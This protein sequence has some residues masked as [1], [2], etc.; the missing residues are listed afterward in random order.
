LID[1]TGDLA[2]AL[3]PTH[4][5]L[6]SLLT[7]LRRLMSNVF[8]P[9]GIRWRLDASQTTDISLDG[10][11]R[12]HLFLI[13]KEALNNV[14]RHAGATQVVVKIHVQNRSLLTTIR[15]DG[16]G[17]DLEKARNPGMGNGLQSMAQRARALGG[18]FHIESSS[19]TGTVISLSVPL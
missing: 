13:L 4:D 12:R 15:D 18:T 17:F 19:A 14:A 3:N 7:R 9:S 5:E 2:W 11:R 1:S 8:E 10:E 6:T 16:R